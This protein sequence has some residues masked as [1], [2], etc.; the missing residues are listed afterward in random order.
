MAAL[1]SSR[2]ARVQEP[3]R[4]TPFHIFSRFLRRRL[5]SG[6]ILR[7]C[8]WSFLAGI[9]LFSGSLYLLALADQDWIGAVTPVGGLAF[10]LGWLSLAWG[11]QRGRS[12]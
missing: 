5:D 7:L 8:C 6:L 4:I 1:V 11:F 12:Q 9:I 10:L 2:P 3:G